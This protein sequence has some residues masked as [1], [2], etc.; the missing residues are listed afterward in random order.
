MQLRHT[1]TRDQ[2]A[3]IAENGFQ[4]SDPSNV[5][6]YLA[7]PGGWWCGGGFFELADGEKPL[8]FDDFVVFAFDVPDD[9]AKLY[10]RYEEPPDRPGEWGI[11]EYLIPADVV[12]LYCLGPEAWDGE[13]PLTD[14]QLALIAARRVG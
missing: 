14:R 2:C 7:P 8:A 3:S 12:N 6:V 9:V 10:A 1:T 4:D 13:P 5:G 11:Y